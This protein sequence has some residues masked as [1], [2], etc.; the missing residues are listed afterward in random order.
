MRMLKRVSIDNVCKDFIIIVCLLIRKIMNN[1]SSSIEMIELKI[2]W[3]TD[4]MRRE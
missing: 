2:C 3:N 1:Y 4:M